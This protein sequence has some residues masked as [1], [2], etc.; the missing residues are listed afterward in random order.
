MKIKTLEQV[1]AMQRKAVRFVRDVL[2]DDLRAEEIEAEDP[3]DY[4]ERKRIEVIENPQR[5]DR[6]MATGPTKAELEER[7]QELESENE[8]L[9]DR[10][11]S[12]SEIVNDD[13]SEED[14]DEESEDDG[15]EYE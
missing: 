6:P 2:G 10:L 1:E 9:R 14:D 8:D 13:D 3:E 11:E 4:A 5:R 7:V 12:I 15:N